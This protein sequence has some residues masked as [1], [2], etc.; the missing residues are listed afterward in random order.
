MWSCAPCVCRSPSGTLTPQPPPSHG[1]GGGFRNPHPLTPHHTPRGPR[2]PRG[3]PVQTRGGE[4]ASLVPEMFGGVTAGFA[5]REAHTARLRRGGEG[6]WLH[7]S[8]AR[9]GASRGGWCALLEV[10]GESG[11]GAVCSTSNSDSDLPL[12]RRERGPGGEGDPS[13]FNPRPRGAGAG[14]GAARR[15]VTAVRMVRS[16]LDDWRGNEKGARE[17]ALRA[18]DLAE[19]VG[20]EPTNE[21][22][23]ITRFPGEPVQPLQHLSARRDAIGWAAS[24]GR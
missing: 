9:L 1:K 5:G 19:R 15:R 14:G 4:L 11:R 3:D 17:G 18:C 6:S 16:T 22:S 21:V 2:R 13:F 10:V 20:F 24:R 12:S 23:P 8:Q 7:S